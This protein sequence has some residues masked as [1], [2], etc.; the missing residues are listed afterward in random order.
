MEQS[1]SIRQ[2]ERLLDSEL[3]VQEI[4]L[5]NWFESDLFAFSVVMTGYS[6]LL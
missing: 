4:N 3:K 2:D 1:F 6:A 5:K